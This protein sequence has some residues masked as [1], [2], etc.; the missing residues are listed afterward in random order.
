MGRVHLMKKSAVA[1]LVLVVGGLSACAGGGGKN[2]DYCKDLQASQPQ[3]AGLQ[4]K[5]AAGL[6]DAFEASHKLAAEAPSEIKDDWAVLDRGM[7]EFENTLKKIGITPD[8]LAAL[9]QG[10]MPEGVQTKDLQALP[11]AYEK[12][13]GPEARQASAAIRKHAKNVCEL[14]LQ[15]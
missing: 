13:A 7:T 1:V 3:I 10:Q 9:S 6:T 8:D 14:D 4:S 12:L 15:I 5:G 2:S 11:K